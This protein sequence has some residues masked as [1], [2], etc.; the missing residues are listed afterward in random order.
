MLD[1]RTSSSLLTI[2]ARKLG[3]DMVILRSEN[4]KDK[5]DYAMFMQYHNYDTDLLEVNGKNVAIEYLDNV[6]VLKSNEVMY[7]ELVQQLYKVLDGNG[8]VSDGKRSLDA[9]VVPEFMINCVI[10]GCS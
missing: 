2:I 7:D 6:G 8:T 5:C 3:H 1:L 9:S 4:A 10:S